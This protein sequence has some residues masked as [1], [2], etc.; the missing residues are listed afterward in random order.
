MFRST[1]SD[2]DRYILVDDSTSMSIE[3]GCDKHGNKTT[4]WKEMGESLNVQMDIAMEIGARTYMLFLNDEN[5]IVLLS[6]TTRVNIRE[7]LK[8]NPQGQTPLYA[9]LEELKTHI[10]KHKRNS[11]KQSLLIYTDG[12]DDQKS[13]VELNCLLKQFRSLNVHIVISLCTDEDSVV[14]F[15]NKASKDIES[16]LDILDDF[17]SEA[18]QVQDYQ[19]WLV[20]TYP[21]H[22][23]RKYMSH[24]LFE[25][26]DKRP[27]TETQICNFVS[28]TYAVIP[29]SFQPTFDQYLDVWSVWMRD[30]KT[31]VY[32][33][34]RKRS[35]EPL[36]ME[37]LRYDKHPIPRCVVCLLVL[38]LAIGMLWMYSNDDAWA[39]FSVDA[40]I[41]M[42][43]A[44]HS[45]DM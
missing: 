23:F 40:W 39:M 14:S 22:E 26:M 30:P 35:C 1:N 42:M 6:E 5:G 13:S 2:I 27:L 25:G 33:V 37:C 28:Y 8:Q 34:V 17:P 19:S 45:F 3:D 10:E 4:R 24:P 12:K 43:S 38:L 21:M 31:K 36:C 29:D 9:K 7:R 44:S 20:Y 16:G 41:T 11:H 15:W 18:A 32:D